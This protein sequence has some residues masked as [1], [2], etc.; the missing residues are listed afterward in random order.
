[1]RDCSLQLLVAFSN[2][3]IALSKIF[4][5]SKVAGDSAIASKV[6]DALLQAL[7]LRGAEPDAC[8]TLGNLIGWGEGFTTCS[9]RS[10]AHRRRKLLGAAPKPERVPK[11]RVWSFERLGAD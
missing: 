11:V 9:S 1:M 8:I 7:L 2:V 3:S 5:A 4:R 10:L 6:V